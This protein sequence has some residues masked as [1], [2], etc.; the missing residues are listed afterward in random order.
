MLQ[1]GWL[2][3]VG[4]WVWFRAVQLTF[5]SPRRARQQEQHLRETTN[6]IGMQVIFPGASLKHLLS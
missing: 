1:E 2:S 6:R 3:V 4:V 5:P